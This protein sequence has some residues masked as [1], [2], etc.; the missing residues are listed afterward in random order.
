[1]GVWNII[2]RFLWLCIHSLYNFG[3]SRNQTDDE[4]TS[5]KY[6]NQQLKKIEKDELFKNKKVDK[7]LCLKDYCCNY[8]VWFFRILCMHVQFV[9]YIL[10]KAICEDKILATTFLLAQRSTSLVCHIFCCKIHQQYIYIYIYPINCTQTHTYIFD[11]NKV[12]NHSF[13]IKL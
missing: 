4:N 13:E 3:G 5:E 8:Y 1:M 10:P 2:E 11:N 6:N 12:Y 9:R 7:K